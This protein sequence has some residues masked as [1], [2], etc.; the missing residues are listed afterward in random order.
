MKKKTIVIGS[1]GSPLALAQSKIVLKK[2]KRK[3]PNFK[4]IIKI[5]KTTGDK[6]KDK[7]LGAIGIKGLFTKELDRALLKRKIDL[8]VHSLK[9]VPVEIPKGLRL[10]AVMKRERANDVFISR[11]GIK[12]KENLPL[13]AKIGTSSLRRKAQLLN[14]RPDL[15]IVDLR[16]NLQTRINKIK[17]ENLEAIVVAWAGLKRLNIKQVNFEVIPEDVILPCVGQAAL[18]IIIREK[19]NFIKT[20]IKTLN[21]QSSFLETQ[22]ERALLLGLGGGCLLPLGARAK[23]NGNILILKA[24]ILDKNGKDKI[25]DK[26]GGSKN[27]AVILGEKLAKRLLAAGCAKWL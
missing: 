24:R 10:A 15:K 11:P 17:L 5:I 18:G 3:Y 6:I 12:L 22:A 21:H 25:E 2:L 23:I 14:F 19:D 9:D 13:G 16:G 1:R 20:I 8:A 7:P 26:T 4:F 27:E